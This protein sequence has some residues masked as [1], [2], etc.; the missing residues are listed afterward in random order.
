LN[1]AVRDHSAEAVHGP[2]VVGRGGDSYA[3]AVSLCGGAAQGCHHPI[4]FHC[5]VSTQ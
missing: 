3:L 4:A 1:L 2:A 5:E